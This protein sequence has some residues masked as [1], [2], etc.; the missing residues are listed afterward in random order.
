[1][2]NKTEKEIMQSWNSRNLFSVTIICLAYNHELFIESALDGFLIQETNFP[3]RV[4]VHEDASIDKTAEIIQKYEKSFPNIIQPIYEIEN[5]YSKK[6]GLLKKVI[7]Q[8]VVGE[9]VAFCEGDDYWIDSFKLQ[10]Q[11][12]FMRK[13]ASC[14]LLIHNGYIENV[15]TGFRGLLNDKLKNQ[16]I[17]AREIIN[18]SMIH[19]PTA[20]MLTKTEYYL[21][22]PDFFNKAPVGDRTLRM[23]AILKGYIYY[24]KE[25]MCVH[26]VNVPGSFSELTIKNQDYNKFVLDEMI[27]FFDKYNEY[28]EYRFEN[29]IKYVKSREYCTYYFKSG[30][31]HK[32]MQTFY[33]KKSHVWHQKIACYVSLYA[34]QNAK[35]I[36]KRF[37]LKF[38]RY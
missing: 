24:F 17:E 37:I 33:F 31:K 1:M 23:Y 18:E 32:A 25:P 3:F 22:M 20:S 15:K 9:Y 6:D 38:R 14:A 13:H 36:I 35:A 21:N 30:R 5:Q 8:H 4:L 28:T 29:E 7:D 16:E 19:P 26:R 11:V 2:V 10:K 12:D 34:P 27:K